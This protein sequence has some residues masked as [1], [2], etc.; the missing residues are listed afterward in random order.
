[1]KEVWFAGVHSDVGGSYP[2]SESQLSKIALRWMLCEAELAGLMTDVR[3]KTDILGAMHPYVAPDPLTKNQ[4]ES[5]HGR[6]WIAEALPKITNVK[7]DQGTWKKSIRINYGRRRWISPGSLVHESVERRLA[8]VLVPYR[9]S[10]LPQQRG[11][12]QDRSATE[13]PSI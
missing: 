2:E 5:L 9:P 11:V 3:Q 12:I 8:N 6:W 13:A 10:N 4:H 1:V 7:N